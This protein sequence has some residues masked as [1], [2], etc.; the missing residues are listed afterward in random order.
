MG[1]Y[2]FFRAYWESVIEETGELTTH[3]KYILEDFEALEQS[4][5]FWKT[6]YYELLNA[7]KKETEK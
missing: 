7:V 5:E 1:T 3:A 2:K 4:R 6:K